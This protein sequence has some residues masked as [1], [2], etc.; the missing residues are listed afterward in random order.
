MGAPQI[1]W[2]CVAGINLLILAFE[3]GR[4]KQG[5]NSIWTALVGTAISIGLLLWGGFFGQGG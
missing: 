4:P 2:I 1:I 5:K 3:H